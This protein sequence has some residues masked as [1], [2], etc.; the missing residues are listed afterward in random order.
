M[1]HKIDIHQ[2]LEAFNQVTSH[3]EKKDGEY[4]LD[5]LWADAGF[6]GYTVTLRDEKVTLTVHF[7]S[8]YD[9]DFPTN[10]DLEIFLQ[11]LERVAGKDFR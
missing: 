2:A 1:D 5:G 6:D 11:R 10:H 9:L 4:V 3:G 8:K 7:H